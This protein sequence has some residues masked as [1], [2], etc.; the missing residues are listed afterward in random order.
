MS[1][2]SILSL[3]LNHFAFS[4][5]IPTYHSVVNWNQKYTQP[6]KNLVGF[7]HAINSSTPP[8]N[9][10]NPLRPTLWRGSWIFSNNNTSPY[11]RLQALKTPL[12]LVVSDFWGYSTTP[13]YANN[14]YTAW[15]NFLI[16]TA[17][18]YGNDFIYDIWNE[19]NGNY[20]WKGTQE[21]YLQTWHVA[22]DTLRNYFTTLNMSVQICGPSTTGDVTTGDG[23]WIQTFVDYALTNHLQVDHLCYHIFVDSNQIPVILPALNKVQSTILKNITYAPLKIQELQIQESILSEDQYSPAAIFATLYSFEQGGVDR[24][25]KGCWNNGEGQSECELNAMDGIT[26]HNNPE[27]ARSAWWGYKLWSDT[28]VTQRYTHTINDTTTIVGVAYLNPENINQAMIVYSFYNQSNNL[29]KMNLNILLNNVNSLNFIGTKNTLSLSFYTVPYSG[30]D[31]LDAPVLI[32]STNI[33]I[34]NGGVNYT[35]SNLVSNN[36]YIVT[37]QAASL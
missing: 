2:I 15:Q 21:Q 8:D 18:T 13:P 22:H 27:Q 19:P 20:F 25:C 23:G 17:K 31:P 10:V 33:A 7:L 29:P 6:I 34:Q 14:N 26:T 3:F 16:S 28:T 1:I 9:L 35:W 11:K 12:V 24:A 5:T 37:I 30:E 32:T 4:Q 36:L